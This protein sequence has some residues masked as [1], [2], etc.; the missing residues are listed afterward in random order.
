[1]NTPQASSLE[2]GAT[3]SLGTPSL[4]LIERGVHSMQRIPGVQYLE[5]TRANVSPALAHVIS[6]QKSQERWEVD[7]ED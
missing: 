6:M 5:F 1:V 7:H 2:L 4:A 3:S